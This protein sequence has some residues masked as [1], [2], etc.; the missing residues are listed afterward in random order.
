MSYYA[1]LLIFIFPPLYGE[2]YNTINTLLAGGD[3][4][5]NLTNESFF[6]NLQS[7][8]TIVLFLMLVILFKVFASSATNGGGGTG[9]VFAPTLFLGCIVGF[10]FSYTLNQL[11]FTT[12]LPQE[13]FAL[14]GMTG[15]MAGVMHAPLTG[16]FLIIELTGGYEL[17]LPLMIVSLV[18]YG[19]ILVFEKHSIYAIRL[20][21]RGELITHHKD[22]AVLTFLKISDLLEKDIP[23]VTPDMTLGD[24][25]KVISTSN[26]NIF[27]V[28]NRDN[29]LLGLVL[30][31]D[32]RNIMFR[33]ELYDKFTVKKF[34]VGSPAKIDIN[35]N[36]EDVMATFEKT[37]AWN[38]P[39]VNEKG[40][41]MGL[42]SQS[43]VFNSYREVLVENY[44]Q[45]Y[46]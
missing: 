30:M 17:F 24:V 7:K 37:K 44:S 3:T 9:G 6:Y 21:K 14:M 29:I 41:Y 16:L 31:N 36:M 11:G 22:K 2:G 40:E 4:F 10:I 39:V 1:S 35:N 33:P 15:V 25:V 28:I 45:D 12:Y 20:A 19:T 26:R 27:P 46:E 42:L 43:S 32:I 8:W 34:M 13:N 23:T 18:S 38:L 5:T